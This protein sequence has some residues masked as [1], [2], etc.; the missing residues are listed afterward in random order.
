VTISDSE[1]RAAAARLKRAFGKSAE[2]MLK[3][4]QVVGAGKSSI[5]KIAKAMKR[6]KLERSFRRR[7]RDSSH[8][9]S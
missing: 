6:R 1:A 9:Q 4:L 8:P 3:M 2:R 5:D 7:P